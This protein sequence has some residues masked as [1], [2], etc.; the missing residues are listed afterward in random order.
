M[1][2]AMLPVRLGVIRWEPPSATHSA[3][4]LRCFHVAHFS[5]PGYSPGSPLAEPQPC[6]WGMCCCVRKIG[7][8]LISRECVSVWSWWQQ[9]LFPRLPTTN[10]RGL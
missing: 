7:L 6:T 8:W 5:E 9:E 3:C 1:S 2:Q 4:R 10:E